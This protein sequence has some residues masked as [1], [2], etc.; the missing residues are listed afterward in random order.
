MTKR[1]VA[2]FCA[3]LAGALLLFAC[4]DDSGGAGAGG[5]ATDETG[6]AE[7]AR[8]FPSCD[9]GGQAVFA[10]AGL[11]ACARCGREARMVRLFDGGS[12]CPGQEAGLGS[13]HGAREAQH[14]CLRGQRAMVRQ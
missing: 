1:H 8:G 12:R 2:A 11:V 6:T 13:T 4:G 7:V 5:G 3:A 14:R 9:P 10:I